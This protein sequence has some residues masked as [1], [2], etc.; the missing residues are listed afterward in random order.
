MAKQKSEISSEEV[1]ISPVA[2]E[3]ATGVD[4]EEVTTEA[5]VAHVE[6]AADEDS[7]DSK[8]ARGILATVCGGVQKGIYTSVYT[9]TY[10]VVYGALLIG[11]LIP[12]NSVVSEGMRDGLSAARKAYDGRSAQKEADVGLDE[13]TAAA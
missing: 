12:V 1:D 9:V 8:P 10:G 13:A 2:E 7:T 3:I 4:V 5:S 11:G 6:C